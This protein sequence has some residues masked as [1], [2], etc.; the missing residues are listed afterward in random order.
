MV[1]AESLQFWSMFW[2]A[3]VG[4]GILVCGWIRSWLI[5]VDSVIFSELRLVGG[6]VVL[7]SGLIDIVRFLNVL[8]WIWDIPLV[9][10]HLLVNF[11]LA[12][13]T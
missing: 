7:R 5:W 13:L 11:W 4:L 6:K 1:L 10:V 8:V 9:G 2:S 3:L 12:R